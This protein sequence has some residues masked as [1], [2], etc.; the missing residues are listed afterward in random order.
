MLLTQ[1]GS[2]LFC[3]IF[4]QQILLPCFKFLKVIFFGGGK[5]IGASDLNLFGVVVAV[6]RY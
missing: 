5:W 3:L 1:A 4:D 2:G 6:G